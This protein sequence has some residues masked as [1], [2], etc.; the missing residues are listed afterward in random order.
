MRPPKMTRV[1]DE[2]SAAPALVIRRPRDRRERIT[3]AASE[4]FQ[5]R[6]YANVHMADVATAVGISTPALY[7][8]FRN[9]QSMLTHVVRS[10]LTAMTDV[11]SSGDSLDEVV[12]ASA[13]LVI[14]HQGLLAVWQRNARHLPDEERAEL[15]RY[16]IAA[17]RRFAAL[18]RKDR[19]ELSSEHADLLAWAALGILSSQTG[20]RSSLPRRR[21]EELYVRLVMA[22]VTTPAGPIG[23]PTPPPLTSGRDYAPS[24]REQLLT[25][26]IRLF[27]ERGYA[28]VSTEDIGAAAGTSGPNVYKHF[29]SKSEVLVAAIIRG[30]ERRAIA[31]D[32]GL[33][34]ATGP[35]DALQRLVR[36]Y[37]EFARDN[38]PLLTVLTSEL[39]Q[40]PPEE[41]RRGIQGQRDFISTWVALLT[42]IHPDV[43]PREAHM[44]VRAALV[45][46]DNLART[47]RLAGRPDLEHRLTDI[48][49]AILQ[50]A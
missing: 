16:V 24:R 4:L 20:A 29:A 15:G 28:S 7:K 45:V 42:D 40:L 44:T 11:A 27:A 18:L 14:D 46:I 30:G 35:A 31:V 32:R 17:E 37:I 2:S 10:G 9:K 43:D 33:T 49:D 34:G 25:E 3:A 36:S 38:A 21:K 23:A 12:R 8:H 22:A 26:A 50:A 39:D 48:A 5:E 47:G 13:E 6:G 1:T 41:R 19:P